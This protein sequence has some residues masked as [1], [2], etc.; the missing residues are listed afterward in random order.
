MSKRT[1]TRMTADRGMSLGLAAVGKLAPA[2]IDILAVG[3]EYLNCTIYN[4]DDSSSPCFGGLVN[5]GYCGADKW[6][7]EDDHASGSCPYWYLNALPTRCNGRGAWRWVRAG[8]TYRCADGEMW[9]WPCG[10][11]AWSHYY[12]ICSAQV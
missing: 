4:Y 9:Y 7:R 2:E 10:A 8:L 5:P 6:H 11:S 3:T 12:T 1:L